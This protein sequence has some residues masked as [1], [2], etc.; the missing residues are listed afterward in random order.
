MKGT[1][2]VDSGREE[3]GTNLST[4]AS[5]KVVGRTMALAGRGTALRAG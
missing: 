5:C 4:I 3:E 2:A 1:V